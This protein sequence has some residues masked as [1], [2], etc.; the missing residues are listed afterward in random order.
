MA[1]L[2][3]EVRV[4]LV[5]ALGVGEVLREQSVA[6]RLPTIV[7]RPEVLREVR[8]LAQ[9]EAGLAHHLTHAT[10]RQRTLTVAVAVLLAVSVGALRRPSWRH[11]AIVSRLLGGLLNCV[12][13]LEIARRNIVH[14]HEHSDRNHA[15]SAAVV[16]RDVGDGIV[17]SEHVHAV[18]AVPALVML[19]L[20]LH[21]R[22]SVELVMRTSRSHDFSG[23][24]HCVGHEVLPRI[25]SVDNL[26]GLRE[27]NHRLLHVVQAALD[28]HLLLLVEVQQVVPQLLLAEDFGIADDDDPVLGAGQ[29]DVQTTRVVQE[30]DALMFV[31]ADARHD[32]DV[33]LAALEGVDGRDLDLLVQLAMQAALVLHVLDEVGALSLVRRD[34]TDLIGTQAGL[35]ET[36]RD[37]LDVRGFSA[38]QIRSPASSDLFASLRHQKEHRTFRRWPREVDFELAFFSADAVLQRALVEEVGR[39]LRELRVHS[40]LHLETERT[41]SQH[42]KSLEKRLREA[43]LGGLLAHDN[44]SELAVI[45]DEDELAGAENNR[46]D[47]F[48]LR[49]LHAFVDQNRVEL[50]SRQSGVASANASAAD[51]ISCVQ[52]LLFGLL[53]QHPESLFISRRQFS[54]F[55]LQLLQFLELSAHV[56]VANLIVKCQEA[57]GRVDGF[58]RLG[59]H[60]ND[61]QVG[62]VD[63][64][65]Q[66]ID[67]G[68]RWRADKNRT[69]I[70]AHQLI[71][72]RC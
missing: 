64:L 59:A 61:F 43:S 47:R 67:S 8:L 66:L 2:R 57:D 71:D 15:L 3:R 41:N 40:V 31:R 69:A 70:Q 4:E 49:A 38:I 9:G 53:F 26:L 7:A 34:D 48:R 60:A 42:D 29:R 12:L 46:N 22:A 45:A 63:F 13:L 51:D 16:L 20:L 11:L 68:V 5:G 23:V 72:N 58:A 10:L 65:S 14:V 37:L 36:S 52:Q 21:R 33:F 6:L 19:L 54:G 55:I 30:A 18:V 39:E 28:Q 35:Q 17:S 50:D 62:L 27:L 56:H 24:V 44:R 1:G 25:E 32:D